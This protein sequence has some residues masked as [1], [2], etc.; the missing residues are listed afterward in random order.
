MLRKQLPTRDYSV[1]A[2]EPPHAKLGSALLNDPVPINRVRLPR[3][4]EVR[5]RSFQ[6]ERVTLEG[7]ETLQLR[8]SES[9]SD[10]V[11]DPYEQSSNPLFPSIVKNGKA[12]LISGV[13]GKSTDYQFRVHRAS[14]E[15]SSVVFRVSLQR[16]PADTHHFTPRPAETWL[17][18]TPIFDDSR[19]VPSYAF[20]DTIFVSNQPVPV[21]EHRALDWPEEAKR[22]KIK[23]WCNNRKTVGT[24]IPLSQLLKE[25]AAATVDGMQLS[26]KP[27]GKD[28]IQVFEASLPQID[29][30]RIELDTGSGPKWTRV[31]HQFDTENLRATH[32][33]NFDADIAGPDGM[34]SNWRVVVTKAK[35]IKDAAIQFR[36]G[37]DV[38]IKEESE[39]FSTSAG[40]VS[41]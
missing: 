35:A 14:R 31:E 32:T 26:A 13:G 21:I 24:S 8:L 2:A 12:D 11:T 34:N 39:Y 36:A 29:A 25:N 10:I 17:E 27:N 4:F 20:Y 28:C 18:V 22:A 33:F 16:M 9:E 40:A 30:F 5:F 3:E 1:H 38:A 19:D 6:P 23:F 37:L 15:K 7:G 41:Q